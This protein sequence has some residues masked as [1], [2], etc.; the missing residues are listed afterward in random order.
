MRTILWCIRC[1]KQ[2]MEPFFEEIRGAME[3]EE[4]HH[5]QKLFREVLDAIEDQTRFGRNLMIRGFF[6]K[7]WT[8]AISNYTNKWVQSKA[9][10]LVK[11][12]WNQLYIPVWNNWNEMIHSESSFVLMKENELVNKRLKFFKKSHRELLHWTQYHLKEYY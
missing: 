9:T 12:L 2:V 4:T 6:S 8:D 5:P 10:A 1:P 3:G 7:K 11:V